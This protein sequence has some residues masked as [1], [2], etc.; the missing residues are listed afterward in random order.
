MG[1]FDFIQEAGEALAEKAMGST[2]SDE[3]TKTVE[4]S[5]ERVN[6]LRGEQIASAIA[7]LDI[8]GEQVNVAVDG[9]VA[10]LTG[11]APSQEALEKM[12]LC[13]G[14]QRGIG[15]VD[16]QLEVDAVAAAAAAGSS[17]PAAAS[18]FYTVKSGDTLGKIAQEHY[19]EASK[20]TVIFEANKPMLSD[21]DKIFPGQ[22]LRIPAL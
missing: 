8:D 21:P 10:T 17:A 12:V 16:C 1:L 18:T 15:K 11:S 2:A 20:Y 4:V 7:K 19:G 22:Q 3:L 9:S 14:N 13:A 6:Q 5:P